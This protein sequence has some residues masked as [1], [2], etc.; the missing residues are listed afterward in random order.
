MDFGLQAS[1]PVVREMQPATNV[2]FGRPLDPHFYPQAPSQ[3]SALGEYLRILSK[4]KWT[5]AA[6]FL[7]IFTVVA[8]ASF[9]MTPVYDASGTLAINKMDSGLAGMNGGGG[10]TFD[11]FDPTD[12]K[13]VV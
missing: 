7:T 1:G 12:Q 13:S 2:E 5:I 8:I 4:H 3:G 6:C 9:R 10:V 11:Y